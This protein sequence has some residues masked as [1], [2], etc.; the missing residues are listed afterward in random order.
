VLFITKPYVSMDFR[1]GLSEISKQICAEW[2]KRL[3]RHS[4]KLC[5]DMLYDDSLDTQSFHDEKGA[6][7]RLSGMARD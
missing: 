7:C 2:Q 1:D 6:R 3:N 4:N 5:F